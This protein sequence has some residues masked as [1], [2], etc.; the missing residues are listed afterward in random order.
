ML[1]FIRTGVYN[2]NKHCGKSK[3]SERLYYFIVNRCQHF[4]YYYEIHICITYITYNVLKRTFH[5]YTHSL[6]KQTH[7]HKIRL[8]FKNAFIISS[9]DNI[10]LI[11][12]KLK[13]YQQLS[14]QFI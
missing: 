8:Y 12:K 2:L 10:S 6:H 9:N 11:K 13:Q 14:N 4:L 7:V 1:A 5:S 3:H